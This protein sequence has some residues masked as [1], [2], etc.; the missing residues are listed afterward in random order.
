MIIKYAWKSDNGDINITCDKDTVARLLDAFFEDMKHK[1]LQKDY[2]EVV[3]MF[4]SIT[5]LSEML[6]EEEQED[7]TV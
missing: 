7:D 2:R 5:R 6:E 3:G 1:L 4:N